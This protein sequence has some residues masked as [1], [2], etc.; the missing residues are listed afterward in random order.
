MSN[1]EFMLLYEKYHKFSASIIY[2]IVKD[3]AET[4][5]LCNDVF[6][7]IYKLGDKL[8]IKNEEKL[9]A[10]IAVTSKNR[11]LDYLK[12]AYVM[13][14]Q[15]TVDDD[16]WEEIPDKGCSPEEQIL[17]IEKSMYQKMVLARL[18]EKNKLNYDIIIKVKYMGI[19]P[20]DVAEEYGITRNNV[21][22]R[23]L[24]AK[25]WLIEELRRCYGQ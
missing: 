16:H 7:S 6:Y 4:D 9:R 14:E 15:C 17:R 3:K 19:S 8:D 21:N 2:R 22:N 10:F 24:R 12:K 23:I 11:A 18:R 5:D 13:Y 20:D 1:E 25:H